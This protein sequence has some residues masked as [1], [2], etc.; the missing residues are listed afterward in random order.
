MNRALRDYRKMLLET[1]EKLEGRRVIAMVDSDVVP[2]DDFSWWVGG[3]NMV[4]LDKIY[5]EDERVYTYSDDR[6]ELGENIEN[7][8]YHEW[9][10]K[11]TEKQIEEKEKD[12]EKLANDKVEELDWEKVLIFHIGV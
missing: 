9:Q 4:S 5:Q 6:E 1:P 3:I 12:L 10:K 7:E 8:I 2:S 11:Y